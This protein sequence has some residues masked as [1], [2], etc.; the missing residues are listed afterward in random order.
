MAI[1]KHN[2]DGKLGLQW[3]LSMEGF[4]ALAKVG[5]YGAR[6]Y[7]QSNWRNGAEYMRYL[8]SCVRHLTSFIRGEDNDGESQLP[9]LA[10]C[11]YNCLILLSWTI[12]KKGIDDRP[13][14]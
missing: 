3:I 7:G 4:D 8:G 5:E 14:L 6:K 12:T 11:A 9:H 13:K 2:D 10:H 1:A